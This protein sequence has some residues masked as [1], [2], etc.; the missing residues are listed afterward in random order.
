MAVYLRKF[1]TQA[2]YDAAQSSLMLP[3]VSLIDETNG[4]EYNTSSPEPP[5]DPRLIAKYNVTD[6][7]EPTQICGYVKGFPPFMPDQD[8]SSGFTSIEIDGVMMPTVSYQ[9]QFDTI[10]EHTIKYTLLDPTS[11]GEMAFYGCSSLTSCTIGSDVTSI[12][13]MAFDGCT[14]LISIT[15]DSSN[16]VYDSRNNCNAIIE[17]STNTLVLGFQNTVIP[18]SVTSIG[19]SAFAGCS[20]LTSI[21]IPDS[22]ISI[23]NSAFYRC[24][25]LTSC[26]IG[27]GVTS[28]DIEAFRDCSSLTSIIIPNSVTSIGSSAFTYCSGLTSCIIGDGVTS[29]GEYAFYNCDGLTSCTIGNGVTSISDRAF[30]YCSSLTSI[31]IP[32]S[33]TSIGRGAFQGCSGLTSIVIPNGIANIMDETF[34]YCTSLT[35]VT[36]PNSVTTIGSNYAQFGPFANCYSLRNVT[37]PCNVTLIGMSAFVSCNNLI[38]VTVEPTTPPTIYSSAFAGNASG[39]KIYVPSASVETY[40]AAEGWSTYAEDIL[41][42]Q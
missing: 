21:V 37:I 39:R 32:N 13:E 6:I 22:V 33:V 40:K 10:G 28:I 30:Y 15:V 14:S 1:A 29:I 5:S 42:I 26:T 25:G 24:S 11:I 17:T 19:D 3:N 4:V 2:A 20:G 38:S 8:Y 27:S 34:A 36:I 35:S 31:D 41:P 9:Y 12:G 18:N 16:T 7:S 23:G